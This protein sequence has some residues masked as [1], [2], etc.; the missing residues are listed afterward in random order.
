MCALCR[1]VESVGEHAEEFAVGDAVVPTFLGQCSEC[2]DCRSPRS[3]MCSKFRFAVRPGMLRDGATRFADAEGRPLHHFLGVSSF[4][5]YTVVDVNHLVKVSPDM[6][7]ALA[8]L[9]SCGASTGWFSKRRHVCLHIFV[10]LASWK[11]KHC[12]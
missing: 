8:C 5:E 9:L 2:V 4:A 10:E 6:P 7:P 12:R 1:V 11:Q 3:N